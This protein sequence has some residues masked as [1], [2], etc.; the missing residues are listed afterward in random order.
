MEKTEI[1][2]DT[3]PIIANLENKIAR[4]TLNNPAKLNTFTIERLQQLIAIFD[5]IEGDKK[6]KCVII[7]AIGD[8]VFSAGLDT[9]MLTGGDPD[10]KTKIVAYGSEL[11]KKVFYSSKF[12]I[13]A[14]AAPA[15]GWG[16]IL[17][18]LCD[19]R[20]ATS[21]FTRDGVAE[22]NYFKLPELEIGIYPATGALTL[23]MMHFGPSLGN[24]M[25]F[26]SKKLSVEEGARMGF[27]NG[28]GETREEVEKL[29]METATKL[30]RLNQQ[31]AMYSK[32]NARMLQPMEYG[33]A[34]DLE[35]R[36]F[37]EML[38]LG[39]EK[40]WLEKYLDAFKNMR[41]TR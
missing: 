9:A 21:K 5:K 34:L 4:I 12:V 33:K 10:I 27:V 32:A 3:A 11:S 41:A 2:P 40:D 6:I 18:M 16:C 19:F 26:L 37:Q 24:D 7:D 20:Y 39:K 8:R 38:D 14:L 31:V 25:L 17:S 35:A 23:C 29:A 36:C 15:V 13:G 28:V 1:A 22:N 30:S